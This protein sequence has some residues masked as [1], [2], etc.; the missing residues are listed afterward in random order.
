MDFSSIYYR[1][2]VSTINNTSC[3][4]VHNVSIHKT[5]DD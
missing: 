4:D 1:I 2:L 3:N 5:D